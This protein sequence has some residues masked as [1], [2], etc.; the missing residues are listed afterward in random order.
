MKSTSRVSR[1]WV[2]SSSQKQHLSDISVGHADTFW[3]RLVGLLNRSSL[4]TRQGLLLSP[5]GSI[6]TFAMRFSIDVVFLDGEGR[7]LGYA[8]NVSPNRVRFAPKGTRKVLEVAHGN[9]S[10][11]GIHLEDYLIF[12]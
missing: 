9:R 5:C 7:V 3:R 2:R 8:D 6:H 12:D 11:T 4:D 10:R 1:L